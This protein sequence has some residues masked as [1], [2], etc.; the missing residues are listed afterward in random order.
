MREFDIDS[1]VHL[2]ALKSVT[3][4]KSHTNEYFDVNVLGT[5]LVFEIAA[6]F[7]VENFVFASSAAVYGEPIFDLVSESHPTNPTN[8]YGETKL[9]A[10]NFLREAAHDAEMNLAVLRFFNIA[11]KSPNGPNTIKNNGL[12][13]QIHNCI[14]SQSTFNVYG[15]NE[16]TNDGSSERDFVSIADTTNSIALAL[17]NP[18]KTTSPLNICS[19][20]ATSVY[21]VIQ[22]FESQFDLELNYVKLPKRSG[23]I[24][25]ICG[26]FELAEQEL[27][28]IPKDDL[29]DIVKSYLINEGNLDIS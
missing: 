5:K 8:Y 18:P 19:G 7:K 4:S 9:Q 26:S 24:S 20:K 6:K 27:G 29:K 2:A 23:E 15:H 17:L 13:D 11:G 16:D 21:Q 12:F 28:F 3:N 22:E 14:T 25:K 10:E 1:I